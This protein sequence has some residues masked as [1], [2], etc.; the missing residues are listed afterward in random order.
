MF[1]LKITVNM[2]QSY[3]CDHLSY[4]SAQVALKTLPLFSINIHT[5]ILII[6]CAR[7]SDS[8][9]MADLDAQNLSR[10]QK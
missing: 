8:D 1:V 10:T 9:E 7:L 2:F 4:N 6:L 3:F 5:S